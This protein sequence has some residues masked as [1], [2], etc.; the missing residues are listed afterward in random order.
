MNGKLEPFVV[1][2]NSLHGVHAVF[3]EV[4][5]NRVLTQIN[6][7]NCGFSIRVCLLWSYRMPCFMMYGSFGKVHQHLCGQELTF[8]QFGLNLSSCAHA[9]LQKQLIL[10]DKNSGF[11]HQSFL[12]RTGTVPKWDLCGSIMFISYL[13]LFLE[14][15][16][17]LVE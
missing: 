8:H 14:Y 7:R 3:T 17:C 2:F 5:R 15:F 16:V 4:Y 12:C 13:T 1:F 10:R 6:E 11:F 9:P